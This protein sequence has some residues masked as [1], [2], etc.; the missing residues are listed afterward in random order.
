MREISIDIGDD[1]LIYAT[2]VFLGN[3][4]L[5]GQFL[6]STISSNNGFI[7]RYDSAGVCVYARDLQWLSCKD[8]TCRPGGGY[9]VTGSSSDGSHPVFL[10]TVTFDKYGAFVALFD[11][12]DNCLFSRL[13][14][15]INYSK[16]MKVKFDRA[17]SIYVSGEFNN[18]VVFTSPA[19][20]FPASSSYLHN[21]FL[22]KYSISGSLEWIKVFSPQN[23]SSEFMI[24]DIDTLEN[25]LIIAGSFI[26]TVDVDGIPLNQ[27]GTGTKGVLVSYSSSGFQENLQTFG[28]IDSYVTFSAIESFGKNIFL[29]G[30]FYGSVDLGGTIIYQNLGPNL[31]IAR[32]GQSLDLLWAKSV[33]AQTSTYSSSSTSSSN[34]VGVKNNSV[35]ITGSLNGKVSFDGIVYDE[36]QYPDMFVAKLNESITNTNDFDADYLNL[37]VTPNPFNGSLTINFCESTANDVDIKIVNSAGLKVFTEQNVKNC[38]LKINLSSQPRGIYFV[39][40]IADGKR[41]SRKVVLQ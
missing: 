11:E 30:S 31:F 38:D 33:D 34:A 6:T 41:S 8:I 17:A 21:N 18:S 23:S 25:S 7:A 39:E 36:D 24:A 35:I 29:T 15:G 27:S 22:C 19:S 5:H 12:H 20:S 32:Y 13:T 28:N 4:D 16:G 40:V 10:N 1:G 26:G 14:D 3:V 37:Q 9:A 2:G